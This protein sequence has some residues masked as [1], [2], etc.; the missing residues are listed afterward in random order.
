MGSDDVM[1]WTGDSIISYSN[2]STNENDT[3]WGIFSHDHGIICENH[4]VWGDGYPYIYDR[5]KYSINN[6]VHP[7]Y[8]VIEGGVNNVK[9]EN[10]LNNSQIYK[11]I[12]LSID[13]SNRNGVTPICVLLLPTDGYLSDVQNK[14]MDDI[15]Q[16]I[17]D[18]HNIHSDFV[19]VDARE[20]LGSYDNTHGWVLDKMYEHDNCGVY[21]GVHLSVAGNRVLSDVIYSSINQ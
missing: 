6:G 7:R 9:A 19:L 20:A 10:N 1:I 8:V 13:Y 18:R 16:M 15:N 14:R 5:F 17:I 12:E 3:V 4:A 2:I 21:D 11:Y